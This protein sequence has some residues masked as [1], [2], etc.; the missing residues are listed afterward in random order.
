MEGRGVG[1]SLYLNSIIVFPLSFRKNNY[2]FDERKRDDVGDKRWLK[3]NL[4]LTR[5]KT[6]GRDSSGDNRRA[7]A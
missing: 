1:L 5:W 4:A 3:R 2:K 6:M 7:Y